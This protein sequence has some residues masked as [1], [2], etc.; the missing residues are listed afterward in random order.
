MLNSHSSLIF[1]SLK[2]VKKLHINTNVLSS[3]FTDTSTY[4]FISATRYMDHESR[5][6]LISLLRWKNRRLHML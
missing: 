2:Q 3:L 5:S 1:E 4:N 6:K